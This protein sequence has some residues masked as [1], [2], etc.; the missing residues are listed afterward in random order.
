MKEKAGKWFADG[1][2]QWCIQRQTLHSQ[3]SLP[4]W[5]PLCF[6]IPPEA[7]ENLIKVTIHTQCHYITVLFLWKMELWVET[8]IVVNLTQILSLHFPFWTRKIQD[9]TQNEKF[10]KYHTE[11]HE[12]LVLF[13]FSLSPI[14]NHTD[15]TWRSS[16]LLF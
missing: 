12:T 4:T 5:C 2:T 15:N 9:G 8:C 3:S 11:Y 1:I 14:L 13:S 10:N 16:V 7:R 6:A